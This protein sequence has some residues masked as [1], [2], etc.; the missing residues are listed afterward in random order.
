[1]SVV[2][3][4]EEPMGFALSKRYILAMLFK[5]ASLLTILSLESFLVFNIC[6]NFE[7]DG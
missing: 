6:C 4:E 7:A 3:C 1:M 5:F 2:L